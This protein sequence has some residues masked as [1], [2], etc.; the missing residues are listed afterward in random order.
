[1]FY[2]HRMI[3]IKVTFDGLYC[4]GDGWVNSEVHRLWDE[5]LSNYKGIFWTHFKMP[6]SKNDQLVGTGGSVYLHPMD[7]QTYVKIIGSSS[8]RG[9]E[10]FP[11][12]EELI[13]F[14]NAIAKHCGGEATVEYV[15]LHEFND[16]SQC[17][18]TDITDYLMEC[19]KK[20]QEQSI[21]IVSHY[22][23]LGY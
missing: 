6:F 4:W 13:E 12:I 22:D 19:V 5:F 23:T 8:C 14:S 20:N 9:R 21:T 18:T 10:T 7:F 3:D 2:S 1:M 17:K 16:N 11:C 15:K